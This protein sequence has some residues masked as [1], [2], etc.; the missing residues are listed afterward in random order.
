MQNPAWMA[1]AW[2]EF[3]QRESSGA[4][5]NPHIVAMYRDAGFPNI[6]ADETAWCAAYVGAILKRAGVAAS[7]SLMARSY[8]N[9]G[10][11]IAEGTSGAVAIFSR[12]SDPSL[13]HVAFWLGETANSVVVLGG[14]QSD[15]VSVSACSK[16]RLLG[17]RIPKGAPL[18]EAPAAPL[19]NSSIFE[20]ALAHVLEMEGGFDDDPFDPG[21]PTNKGITLQTLAEWMRV[22]IDAANAADLKHS[23]KAIPEATV[24]AIYLAR[25]WEPCSASKFQPAL[26]LMHFDAA[27]N[28]GVGS[29]N[30]LLQEAVGV[31][32]DGE[33]G[34]GTLRAVSVSE[35]AP[36][37]ARYAELRRQRYRSLP[38]F[39]RFGRGWMRRVDQTLAKATALATGLNSQ[40]KGTATM[41]DPL[42]QPSAPLASPPKWWGQSMTIWG[43]LIAA[44]ATVLPALGPLIG[45][46]LTSDMIQQ[47]G[48]AIPSAIQAIVALAGTVMAIYGRLRASQPLERRQMTLML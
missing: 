17:L 24:R 16:D 13:G 39:W 20:L 26:A 11:A 40:L 43:A 32:V 14:N 48:A 5:D 22:T 27:V 35:R 47:L 41:N 9:W 10:E 19:P 29:A 18:P 45:I 3:G 12:G 2:R 36:L 23:L 42:T 6:T 46:T 8:L 28:H 4:S 37:L 44:A 21:G 30:R 15:A 25:Y 31:T 38:A 33:I 1:E 34:P 7:G